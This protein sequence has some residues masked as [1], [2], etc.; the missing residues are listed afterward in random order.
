MNKTSKIIKA[1]KKWHNLKFDFAQPMDAAKYTIGFGLTYQD[2][3]DAEKEI[4]EQNS[5]QE[6]PNS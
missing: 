1:L 3:I 5:K 2:L 6:K 4:E